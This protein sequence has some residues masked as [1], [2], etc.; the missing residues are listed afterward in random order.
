[1][2]LYI[3][4]GLAGMIGALLRY[5]VSITTAFWWEGN[6]P[7]ATLLTNYIGCFLLPFL[8]LQLTDRMI[9]SMQKAITTGLIG[10][11]TTFSTFS[12]E[13]IALLETG[14]AITA[15]GY[16]LLSIAGGLFFVHLGY[17]RGRGL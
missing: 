16:V 2:L 15:F 7:L 4:I 10:S 9:V 8:T 12:V 5:T 3:S 1:M 13:T 11:F 14:E 6:F 17:K